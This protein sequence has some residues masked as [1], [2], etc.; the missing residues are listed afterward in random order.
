MSEGLAFTR[1]SVSGCSC[2]WATTLPIRFVVVSEPAA[3]SKLANP[4]T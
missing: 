2:S 4:M 1:S 3:R